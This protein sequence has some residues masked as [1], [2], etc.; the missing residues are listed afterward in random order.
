MFKN[1]GKAFFVTKNE[2]E[3]KLSKSLKI[4]KL[5]IVDTSGGCGSSFSVK[6]KSPDFNGMN[7]IK[8]HRKVNEILKDE[9]KELHALQLKTEG[10]TNQ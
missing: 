2:I 6:I 3:I 1:V 8:M 4:T 5:E 9:F 7:I 10:D